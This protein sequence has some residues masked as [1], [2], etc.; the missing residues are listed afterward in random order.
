MREAA[1][2][3]ERATRSA[4]REYA[5]G[6]VTDED[7]L[8]GQLTGELNSALRGN[9]RGFKWSTKILRHRR[10]VAAEEKRI[11]ADLLIH[12]SIKAKGRSY[13]K[14]VLVQSKRIEPDENMTKGQLEE[15]QRQCRKM[16]KQSSSSFVFDYAKSGLRVGS[17]NRIE[18]TESRALHAECT[19]TPFR[20][21]Y[22]L[23]MCPIG[24]PQIR[25]TDLK[26]LPSPAMERIPHMLE[27]Q[28][29]SVEV[30]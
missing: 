7:D 14:G 23:F 1:H 4:M 2:V 16:L 11:G 29:Q 27:I 8:T 20:F 12:V 6:N 15:L 21:F 24:D 13:S 17:A 25:G 19:M 9:V 18:G 28:A 22:D 30:L 5:R 3:A 26:S 10:G